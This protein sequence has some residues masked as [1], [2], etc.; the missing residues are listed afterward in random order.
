MAQLDTYLKPINRPA[1]EQFL[2]VEATQTKKSERRKRKQINQTEEK[3]KNQ[4]M[5][6][7]KPGMAN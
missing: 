3:R 2:V 4:T 7:E 6:T 5:K 1:G